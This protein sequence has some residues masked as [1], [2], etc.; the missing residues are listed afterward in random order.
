VVE[1]D[2][3]SWLQ[4]ELGGPTIGSLFLQFPGRHHR[5]GYKKELVR[6]QLNLPGGTAFSKR[7]DLYVAGPVFGPGAVYQV[8]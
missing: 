6:G 3:A 7:G 5:A 8:K 4:F 2:R 1:L